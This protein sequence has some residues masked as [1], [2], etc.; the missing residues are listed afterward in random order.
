MKIVVRE[1]LNSSLTVVT[2][3][4]LRRRIV[5]YEKDKTLPDSTDGGITRGKKPRVPG[6]QLSTLNTTV[7]QHSGKIETD[8]DL[9]KN[10]S[11]G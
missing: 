6:N 10:C 1:L 3:Q 11:C 7:F 4:I 9:S 8:K 5:K 2:P